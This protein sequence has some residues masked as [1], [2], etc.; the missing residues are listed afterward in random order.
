MTTSNTR[1]AAIVTFTAL[2][3]LITLAAST[4]TASPLEVK[5]SKTHAMASFDFTYSETHDFSFEVTEPGAINFALVCDA[6]IDPVARM[7]LD[8]AVTSHRDNTN[9]ATGALSP[10]PLFID[11]TSG[12][13]KGNSLVFTVNYEVRPADIAHTPRW[14]FSISEVGVDA[15]SCALT[16]EH[17]GAITDFRHDDMMLLGS[18]APIPQRADA[19][20][21]FAG[22][23]QEQ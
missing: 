19:K 5:F 16:I 3:C 14:K 9:A 13:S 1:T 22:L 18:F 8:N 15:G 7:Q 12:A 23:T 6:P 17:S 4:T 10:I 2:V 21:L 20:A 11:K